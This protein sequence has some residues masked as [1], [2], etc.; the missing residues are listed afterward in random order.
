MRPYIKEI[1]IDIKKRVK[2]RRMYLPIFQKLF[3]FL[4]VKCV[5][6]I[7]YDQ[8]IK[9]TSTHRKPKINLEKIGEAKPSVPGN[10]LEYKIAPNIAME[11]TSVG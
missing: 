1:K 3:S 8:A 4:A 10:S 5:A 9:I 6:I 2:G 7:K 11:I